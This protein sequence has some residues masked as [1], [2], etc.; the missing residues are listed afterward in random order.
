MS[1]H[2]RPEDQARLAR[3]AHTQS[4]LRHER[5]VNTRI[6]LRIAETPPVIPAGNFVGG[7]VF[8]GVRAASAL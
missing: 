7:D 6:S 5:C 2:F 8:F 4:V 1:T 3:Q